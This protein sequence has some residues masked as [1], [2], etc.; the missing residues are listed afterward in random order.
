MNGRNSTM[1]ATVIIDCDP[2]NDDAIALLLALAS[3]EIEVAAITV[4]AG[5]VGLDHTARNARAVAELARHPVPVYAGA[6]KPLLRPPLDAAHIHGET[7]LKGAELPAPVRALGPG[8]AADFLRA[9]LRA[10]AP[11]SVTLCALGPLTNLALALAIEPAI[12]AGIAR[13]VLMGG[14]IGLGNTSPAAEFN[15]IADP[16][17]AAIVF[18]A[19]VPIVMV[20]IDLTHQAIATGPRVAA[21][22]ATGTAFSRMFDPQNAWTLEREGF[23]LFKGLTASRPLTVVNCRQGPLA[24]KR[25]RQALS[26]AIDRQAMM[27]TTIFGDGVLSGYIP[28][29]DETW[30]VPVSEFEP[31]S[32]PDIDRAKSLLADAG[33]ANGFDCVM[34][35]SPQYAFDLSN[36]QI[37]QQQ[38]AAIGVTM[39]IEQLEWG[40]L[41]DVYRKTRDFDLLNIILT[42]QPDP[43]GY[44]YDLLH[45]E[46]SQN[47]PGI[48]D[49]E[50]DAMLEKGRT[51]VDLAERQAIYRDIQLKLENDLCP[52]LTTF[53]YHQYWPAQPYVMDY[54]T[55]PSISRIDIRDIWLNK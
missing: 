31:Y 39:K 14:A 13:I 51:T 25:V 16:H 23:K 2:G 4:V 9:T 12:A 8:T 43:D 5:N 18:A 32:G 3:P 17:A 22:R 42:Y 11:R 40:N 45:S 10:A 26:W 48:S 20:P 35:V 41:L 36:A 19:G 54:K 33:Y 50:L 30:G 21:I 46:S 27:D 24:D 47:H 28:V 29:A 7:G 53:E 37:M 49:P 15:M 52:I 44:L 34:K 38:L 1:P 55:I 6:V